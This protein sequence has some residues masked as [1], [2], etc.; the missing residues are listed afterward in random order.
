MSLV[1]HHATNNVFAS[2]AQENQVHGS[3]HNYYSLSICTNLQGLDNHVYIV[4]SS[5]NGVQQQSV[6]TPTKQKVLYIGIYLMLSD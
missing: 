4:D 6:T 3:Y 1:G 2:H 5:E